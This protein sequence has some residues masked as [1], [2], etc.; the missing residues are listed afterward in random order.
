MARGAPTPVP[1]RAPH[2]QEPVRPVQP[3]PVPSPGNPPAELAQLPTP[4]VAIDGPLLVHPKGEA[5]APGQRPRKTPNIDLRPIGKT[6][7]AEG[8]LTTIDQP[9]PLE[10]VTVDVVLSCVPPSARLLFRG[11]DYPGVAM[12]KLEPGSYSFECQFLASCKDCSP[13]RVP[14]S[15]SR[16]DAATGAPRRFFRGLES[17]APHG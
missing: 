6:P 7:V 15:I 1:V 9:E 17:D 5:P 10:V 14:F 13:L 2:W 16:K 12:L 4:S 11:R 8:T 3:E